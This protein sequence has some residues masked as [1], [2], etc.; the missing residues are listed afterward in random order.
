MELPA[1]ISDFDPKL[2]FEINTDNT[3]TLKSPKVEMGQGIFTGFAM[4]AAEE[5]DMSLDQIKVIHAN[6]TNGILG[7]TGVSNSTSSL[8]T[9]IREIAATLRETLKLQASKVWNVPI[10]SV[11]TRDGVLIGPGKKMTYAELAGQVT[12]WETAPTPTLRPT[13]SFKYVGTEQKRSDLKEKILAKP[14]YGIDTMLPDMVYGSVA[15]SPFIGGELKEVDLK[16]VQGLPG[17]LSVVQDKEWV[18]VVAKSRYE[19]ETALSS[20]QLVWDYDPS[21]NTS[22]TVEAVTV[23]TGT[24]VTIQK[25]G[26]I[27]DAVEEELISEYR[28]PIG[29]HAAMEP[30]IVVADVKGEQVTIYTSHQHLPFMQQSIVDTLGFKMENVQ[31]VP[32]F[33]GGGF[34]RKTF[35]HNAVEAVKLSQAAGRPVHL[36]FTRQQEFQNGFV[37]P[38]THHVLKGSLDSSGRIQILQHD[39]AT[40]P[41]GFMAV[42]SIAATILGADFIVAGHGARITYSIKNV[43][44]TMWQSKLP[45]E[46]C[47]WRG[48]GMFA[49]TFAIESFMDELADK[50]GIDPLKFRMEYCG[51]SAQLKRRRKLLEILGQKSGWYQEKS[52]DVGFG[53]AVCDDH[54]TIA[55]AV[56][57]LKIEQGK[58]RLSKVYQAIDAGKI[59][60]PEGIRQQVEGAT[61]MAISASL[62]EQGLIEGGQFVQT[63]FHNYQV[64]TLKDTPEIE[65]ILHEGSD[66][67]SGVGEPSISPIAPAIANA[68]F[69]LTGKRLRSLPL[70]VALDNYA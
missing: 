56:V 33:L 29:F 49:N 60:N 50:A 45:F 40:G 11:S 9:I 23:G 63:N 12:N 27:P 25:E 38:N 28:T 46:T 52:A 22:H 30:S 8:Y 68:I 48:V 10:A 58:I 51:E 42:P 2:W 57:E 55:A 7:N 18:G 32:A 19:A 16:G 26:D 62:Y 36:L 69:S 15:Y 37:R 47:M 43:T 39:L 67:P 70:Q 5:L 44:T 13:T 21:Y 24:K 31:I 65:V 54:K 17:V 66:K 6:S 34:G 4:L 1:G 64:A 35:K 53:M 20:I 61:M 14:I 3:I 59:I 41:M